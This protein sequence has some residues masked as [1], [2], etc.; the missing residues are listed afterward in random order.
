MSVPKKRTSKMR[1]DQRRA[2]DALTASY[3]I[4]CPNCGARTKQHHA[5]GAC[6]YYRGREIVKMAEPA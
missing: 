5:C 4:I 1:R 3:G 2:H 6:G